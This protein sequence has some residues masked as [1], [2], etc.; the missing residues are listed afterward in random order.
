MRVSRGFSLLELL[1]TLTAGSVVLL[2][3]GRLV[4]SVRRFWFAEREALAMRH[5]LRTVSTILSSELRG[6][7]PS[8]GDLLDI[9]DT[10]ITI[11]APR[12]LYQLCANVAA[13][14]RSV[15]VLLDE[16]L[17]PAQPVAGRV[18]AAVLLTGSAD[19]GG[20]WVRGAVS[21]VGAAACDDGAE[22]LR[23]ELATSAGALDSACAGAPVRTF[24]T[25]RYRLYADG[26]GQWWLGVRSWQGAAWS[27]TS[28][29][30]G[31]LRPRTGLA[32]SF[33]DAAGAPTADAAAV[34]AV[35]IAVAAA[36]TVPLAGAGRR[37]GLRADSLATLVAPRNR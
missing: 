27:S 35:G 2:A 33:R 6:I 7:S 26:R 34:R 9:S 15:I 10:A 24:E 28:P 13:G 12:G 37:T 16:T 22:G 3:T 19:S 17:A 30:A 20:R 32:F 29:L 11:R 4:L 14:S 8:S 23:L 1:L 36:G 18:L 31:P 5:T 21:D 25:L